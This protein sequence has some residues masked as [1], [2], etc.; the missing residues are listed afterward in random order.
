MNNGEP[1]IVAGRRGSLP[2]QRPLK[3]PGISSLARPPTI[4]P[5]P[6]RLHPDVFLG[7]LEQVVSLFLEQHPGQA[8]LLVARLESLLK[9]A[10]RLKWR[11]LDM[12]RVRNEISGMDNLVGIGLNDL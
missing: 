1:S 4:D 7:C 5:R 3:P 12:D 11:P 10:G 2:N 9:Q 6:N 8:L